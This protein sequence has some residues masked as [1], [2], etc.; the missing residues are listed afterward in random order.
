MMLKL[1][2]SNQRG[3]VG[4]TTT[5]I[6][7]ARCLADRGKRVLIVDTDSQGSI[8]MSLSLKPTA[9]LHQFINEQYAVSKTVTT[10]HPSIDVIC[11]DRRTMGVE[12][13][14]N[15]AVAREMIFTPFSNQPR[16]FTTL[17][18]STSLPA[19]R[20]CRVAQWRMRRTSWSPSPWTH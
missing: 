16:I 4:K 3:G 11:S 7:L 1:V 12:G 20:I 15:G 17:S 8:W 9:F 2:V 14:L 18:Y 19:S 10:A 5:V 6:T 13:I